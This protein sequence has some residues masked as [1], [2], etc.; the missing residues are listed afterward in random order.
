MNKAEVKKRIGKL[1]EEINYH[2]YQYHVLDKLA[3]SDAAFDSLKNELEELELKYPDLVT[4]DSPTQRVGG[5]PLAKFTKVTHAQ[6]MLSLN[7]AFGEEEIFAWQERIQKLVPHAKPDYFCELKL[8]GLAVSLTY[9]NGVM[10][11]GATRG[12]GRVGEDVTQNLKTIEAIPLKLRVPDE[13]E[14]KKARLGAGQIKK[15]MAAVANGQIEVRGEAIM[16][17]KVFAAL[18]KKY[19]Q[20]GKALLVNP[21]NGAAGSI[22]QLDSKITAQ[23]HLDFF[24]Y[25]IVTNLGQERHEQE[26]LI[27]RALGFPTFV[28]EDKKNYARF[29]K[30][31]DEVIKFHEHWAGRRDKLPFGCDGVVVSVDKTGLYQ[32]LGVVGKAPRWMQAFKFSGEEATTEVADIVVQVGRTGI[33]TPVAHLKPV[34]VGGVMVARATLHNEDEIKRLGLKIGD[35]VIVQRAGDV[36]PDIIKVLPKLRTGKEKSFHMP[37]VC[38]VCGGPVEKRIIGSQAAPGHAKRGAGHFCVN[39]NCFAVNRRQLHHFAARSAMDIEGLGPKIIDH[40]MKE[41]L[42]GDAADIYDLQAGDLEPLER[43]AVKSASNVIASI[44]KSRQVPLARFINALGILHVGEETAI[45]LANHFGSIEKLAKASPEEINA[46]ANIGPI[47]AQSISQWLANDKNKKLLA[48]LL[49]AVKIIKPAVSRKKQV[50][51]GQ[52]LVLTG[53]LG[54]LSRD[55]AK[56]AIRE[57]GGE[58]ASSVSPK[59]NLVVAGASPGS[60]YDKAKELGVKIINE[61]GFLKLIK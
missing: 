19:Q 48:K 51:K 18:N 3:M 36:I 60:K 50:F 21:R 40:L 34:K 28:D 47:V 24:A 41:G 35:T 22:R 42:I 37:K 61:D 26:H 17:K 39:K 15:I 32:K 4:A 44:N 12:D 43:F 14:L 56:Q 31:L 1:R 5:Q 8:D 7:D 20:Q 16:T 27:A 30:N 52:T 6:R 59:T 10:V 33:L 46:I 29:C 25:T 58:V 55:Q 13:A 23:R 57:R 38:P 9:K 49:K 2:R 45:D 11:Q 53:E 54:S